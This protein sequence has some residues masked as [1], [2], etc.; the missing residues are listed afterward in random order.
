MLWLSREIGASE[1]WQWR[2][3]WHLVCTFWW[4]CHSM[5]NMLTLLS[6]TNALFIF[7]S[8]CVMPRWVMDIKELHGQ[9]NLF[10]IPFSIISLAFVTAPTRAGT[11]KIT[12]DE[13][14]NKGPV[15]KPL[16][17]NKTFH[18]FYRNHKR[19]WEQICSNPLLKIVPQQNSLF[20]P[21]SG[22]TAKTILALCVAGYFW[23]SKLSSENRLSGARTRAR[24]QM[25]VRTHRQEQQ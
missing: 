4:L 17:A 12:K 13:G 16:T 21:V 20:T 6:C 1:K 22:T 8:P 15:V 7:M 5:S 9:N 24:A 18:S 14:G 3:C 25:H 23:T 19:G 2:L 10:T 11:G